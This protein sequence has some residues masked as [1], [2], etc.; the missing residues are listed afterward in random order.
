MKKNVFAFKDRDIKGSSSGG[1][2]P[3]IVHLFFDKYEN[4]V[5]YGVKYDANMTPVFDRA[6]SEE[7]TVVF[8]GSKYAKADIKGLLEN[9]SYDLKKGNNVL[10]SGTPCQIFALK[11]YLN[12]Q[13]TS[14]DNLLTIDLVCHGTPKRK[15]WEG[16]VELLET[17]YESSVVGYNFRVK[18]RNGG[19]SVCAI[20]ADGRTISDIDSMKYYA[21]LFEKNLCLPL[22]CFNCQFR[23]KELERPSDITIGD[24]WGAEYCF[25]L[26][27]DNRY[28]YSLILPNSSS[29]KGYVQELQRESEVNDNRFIHKAQNDD[30]LLYNTHLTEP[31]KKP[32]NY[33]E[34][35][36][37]YEKL[38][39]ETTLV[40]YGKP[41]KQY[42]IRRFLIC[43]MN[44]L[45][46]KPIVLKARKIIGGRKK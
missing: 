1:A 44:K 20:L 32:S 22:G 36:N 16:L 18:K 41:S 42:Q 5:V 26:P 12:R 39:F 29:G 8:R 23:N 43:A 31:N 17:K 37:D 30:W 15:L 13:N 6:T 40:K 38:E 25:S 21:M 27:A 10:V 24:F 14:V 3:S 34:F 2:F 11:Q 46:L 35:W 33:N 7:E 9:V 28:D 4:A 45:N 19:N